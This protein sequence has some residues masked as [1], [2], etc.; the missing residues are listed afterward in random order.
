M[1]RGDSYVD[2]PHFADIERRPGYNHLRM[3]VSDINGKDKAGN[4]RNSPENFK[5][6]G[7]G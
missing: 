4:E 6:K 2:D 5:N 1:F 3:D 7:L